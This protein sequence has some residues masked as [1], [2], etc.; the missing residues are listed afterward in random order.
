MTGISLYTGGCNGMGYTV[1]LESSWGDL[2]G[3]SETE[4]TAKERRDRWDEWCNLAGEHAGLWLDTSGC[5]DCTMLDGAWCLH[6]GLP[7]TV[8]PFLTLKHG[9]MGMACMGMKPDDHIQLAIW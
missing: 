2:L 4:M 5:E 1:T 3:K 6:V 9:M 7:C 8:S